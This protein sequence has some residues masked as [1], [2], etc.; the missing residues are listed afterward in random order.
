MSVRLKKDLAGQPGHLARPDGTCLRPAP[1][2]R[3][4]GAMT[5]DTLISLQ[6]AATRIACQRMTA[7]HLN[8]LHASVEQ[9]SC[10]AAP[11]GHPRHRYSAWRA[12]G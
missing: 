3:D 8:A 5:E 12:S 1:G 7:Q 10:A 4:R 2:T 6:S 9:A 11:A